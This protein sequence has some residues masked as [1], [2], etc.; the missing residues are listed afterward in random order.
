MGEHDKSEG[1]TSVIKGTCDPRWNS[2]HLFPVRSHAA[3]VQVTADWCKQFCPADL[4]Y[5][6]ADLVYCPVDLAWP[7]MFVYDEDAATEDDVLGMVLLLCR[8]LCCC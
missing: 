4:A 8:V 6:P 1:K 2:D 3:T 5:C 7:Q